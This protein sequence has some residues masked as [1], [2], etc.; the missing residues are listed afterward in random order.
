MQQELQQSPLHQQLKAGEII[1][2]DT[3]GE[4]VDAK[5]TFTGEPKS[6]TPNTPEDLAET[7]AV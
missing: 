2:V 1:V 3:E 7:P 4:G 6:S 5:F